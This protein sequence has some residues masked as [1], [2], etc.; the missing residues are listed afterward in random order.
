MTIKPLCLPCVIIFCL[1]ALTPALAETD[2]DAEITRLRQELEEVKAQY[3][4][5]M[6]TMEERLSA[7][8]EKTT[9]NEEKTDAVKKVV[10][11]TE[12]L[13]SGFEFG[14]YLR[15][16]FGVNSQ[17]GV[18]EPFQAPGAGA[19]YRLGNEAEVYGELV[20]AKNWLNFDDLDGPFFRTQVRMS[21]SN[22]YYN[23]ETDGT[24]DVF[25]IREA[26]AEMGNFD[27]SPGVKFWVGQRFY[28]RKHIYINDYYW[29]DMS[30]FGGGVEDIP[31]WS[32][33]KLALAYLGG[34]TDRY[35]FK[36]IGYVSKNTID[37][38]LYDVNVPLGKGM[39]WLSGSLVKGGTYT[40][41]NDITRGYPDANGFGAGF[42]HSRDDFLGLTDGY[43]EI[44]VQY[45]R[46]TS[47]DFTTNVQDPTQG[48]ADAW[49]FQVT[50]SGLAQITEQF[51][52]MPVF[53]FEHRDNGASWRS[54][55]M[56][57]SGGLRPIWHFNKHFAVSLEGGLDWVASEPYNA[58]GTLYK[59]SL[60]PELTISEDI[61]G[62]PVLRAFATYAGWTDGLKRHVGG[63][64]FRNCLDGASFGLQ[65]EAW[66]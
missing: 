15:S 62:R 2:K 31:V 39:F 54:E 18:M 64:A 45:G 17:G 3:A 27:W 34:S 1:L 38:R 47:A 21:F 63:S 19:K 41:S 44:S 33:G 9:R 23:S 36:N 12:K 28:R 50:A 52:V 8:E 43:Q 60:A 26:Y 55:T 66:W 5:S 59:I 40:D 61:M 4:A 29:L 24:A 25:A 16:G 22:S 37:I 46:G 11:K 49:N 65:M 30:G 20:L 10:D 13:A 42:S 48:L 56:W 58:Y 57:I 7:L 51:A 35:R 6:K 14:G 32:L 53:I